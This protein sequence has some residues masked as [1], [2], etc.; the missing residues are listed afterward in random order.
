MARQGSRLLMV[1]GG[2]GLVAAAVFAF[3]T[4]HPLGPAVT[5]G[6]VW[7]VVAPA[8]LVGAFAVW[9]RPNHL[10]ARWLGA[11]GAL[12]A[13]ETAIRR[14][15]PLS[16][17]LDTGWWVAGS[18]LFQA[19]TV[20]TT[21][22]IASLLVVFPDDELR[23]AY[24]RRV[25]AGIW[26]TAAAIPLLLLFS[27][28]SLFVPPWW[29]G[30]GVAN[31]LYVGW[32]ASMDRIAVQAFELRE[33]MW[34]AGLVAMVV[35]Y[36]RSAP[37]AR[38]RFMWPLAAAAALVVFVVVYRVQEAVFA[39]IPWPW[40]LFGGWI[41]LS[42]LLSV[43]ILVAI[44]RY[45]LIGVDLWLRRSILFGGASVIIALIYLGLAAFIGV[46][47]G[48]QISLVVGVLVTLAAVVVLYPA[49]RRLDDWARQ[50]VFGNSVPGSEVLRR[51]G[52]TLEDA[53]DITQIGSNLV[54]TMVEGLDLEWARISLDSDQETQSLP[55][56]ATGINRDNT[57]LPDFVAPLSYL[58]TRIGLLE[59]GPKRQG[60]LSTDDEELIRSVARQ[61]GLAMSNA[62][63]A[64]EL[65]A[66]LE[67]LDASRSRMVHAQREERH[68]IERNIHDGVQQEIIAS[69]AKIRLA[70]N[71]LAR[72]PALAEATLAETQAESR[73]TL[74]HLR[75]LSRGIHPSV[76]TDRGLVDAFRSQASTLPID[77]DIDVTSYMRRM[78]FPEE[79][80]ESAYFVVSEGL[81]NVLKHAETDAATVRL[82]TGNQHLTVEVIDHGRGCQR[83]PGSGILGLRDRLDSIGG[84]LTVHSPSGGGTILRAVLPLRARAEDV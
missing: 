48:Q 10:S 4:P 66:R 45:R 70:R 36:R 51:V 79:I 76:L 27:S 17:S 9:V 61:A 26:L 58:D 59:C 20:A 83:E 71:Q 73:Q 3:K 21:A 1:L 6:W 42:A 29:A 80:E 65:E 47:A 41:P 49:R 84:D 74:E 7:G 55:I 38:R 62:R 16:E 24:Q 82:R 43:S 23:Y 53:Y 40:L 68:R 50:W 14:L 64:S 52:D 72:D 34:G 69:I 60:E 67:E 81:T 15:L 31:P 2:L 13:I 30:A 44:L 32:L 77:V 5:H 63:L 25:L 8:Y 78:R 37:N 35:R 39:P 22:S 33:M 18:I 28:E 57:A 19:A 54:R 46:A 56:A 11:M 12:V 75:E